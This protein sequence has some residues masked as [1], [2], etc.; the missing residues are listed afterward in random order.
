MQ[1]HVCVSESLKLGEKSIKREE[2]KNLAMKAQQ[3]KKQIGYP[4]GENI[5][6]P[7]AHGF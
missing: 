1:A 6:S 5:L 2:E 7:K 4:S 3:W